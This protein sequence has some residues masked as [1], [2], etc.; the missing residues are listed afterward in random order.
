MENN[1]LPEL[2]RIPGLNLPV[3][4][5]GAL[6]VCAL[7]VGIFVAHRQALLH[8]KYYND[9][10][11][12][13]FYALLGGLIGARLL[14]IMVEWRY[15]FIEEP[16]TQVAQSAFSIPTVLALWKGGFV[17]WGGALGGLVAA[18]IFCKKRGIPA[19]EFADICAPGLAI[20]HAIGR[21]GC[22]AAGCCFGYES[23]H[24]DHAG[25]VIADTPFAQSYPPGSIAYGSLLAQASDS[26]RELMSKLNGTLPLFPVQSLESVG[27]I[28]IF[29]ML[30]ALTPLKRAHGQIILSYLILYSLMRSFTETLR[31][32]SA[33]GFIFDNLLSTSQFISL[34][35]STLALIMIIMLSR[36]HKLANEHHSPGA[37]H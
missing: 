31:G 9:V 19:L 11:D 21:L 37:Q 18:Y 13:S 28:A 3:H 22:V 12:F 10:S 34:V 27:N 35:I 4:T 14:F 23:F 8:K 6:I 15:Y 2:F 29:F 17:F 26:T 32:D 20:G 7:M 5:Y 33:R 36:R 24:L 25:N 30:M 1:M 16:F